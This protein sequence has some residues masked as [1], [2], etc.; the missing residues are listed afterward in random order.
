MAQ[1]E[2]KNGEEVGRD[3]QKMRK[4]RR[5]IGAGDRKG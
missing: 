1:R 4:G 2:G 5:R 3:N